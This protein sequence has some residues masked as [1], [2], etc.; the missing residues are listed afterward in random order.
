VTPSKEVLDTV[1]RIRALPVKRQIE[2]L[3]ELEKLKLSS[4]PS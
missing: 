3:Q 1:S 2:V 4:Q